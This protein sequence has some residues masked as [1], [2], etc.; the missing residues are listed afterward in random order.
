VLPVVVEVIG[1]SERLRPSEHVAGA[2]AGCR[3]EVVKPK[4][5]ERAEGAC[6]VS[7]RPGGS[8]VGE[9]LTRLSGKSDSWAP[10]F[11]FDRPIMDRSQSAS[12]TGRIYVRNPNSD[13]KT[14]GNREEAIYTLGPRHTAFQHGDDLF[15]PLQIA[16]ELHVIGHA[17]AQRLQGRTRD[18]QVC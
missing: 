9:L 7:R 12:L 5:G 13:Q 11:W 14:V 10:R 4:H 15:H 18:M 17:P 1:I 16:L 3:Q 6:P 8:D 2:H